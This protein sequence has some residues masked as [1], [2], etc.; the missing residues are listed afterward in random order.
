MVDGNH[1]LQALHTIQRTTPDV[2]NEK[3]RCAVIPL[4]DVQLLLEK[5]T[6]LNKIRGIQAA[7]NFYDL[8]VW[9]KQRHVHYCNVVLPNAITDWKAARSGDEKSGTEPKYTQK[10][11]IN[12]AQLQAS[13]FQSVAYSSAT[14]LVKTALGLYA[15][16]T[17]FIAGKFSASEAD[18]ELAEICF[19]RSSLGEGSF[20]NTRT[21]TPELQLWWIQV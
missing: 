21:T 20:W 15:G 9:I 13:S 18:S 12:W 19:A 1:R 7:D 6:L 4:T 2:F 3:V 17:E 14:V 16:S 8:M 11:F 10:N 5:G